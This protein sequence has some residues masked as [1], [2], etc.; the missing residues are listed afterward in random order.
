MKTKRYVRQAV[1]DEMLNLPAFY[2]DG[3]IAKTFNAVNLEMTEWHIVADNDP[4]VDTVEI[5]A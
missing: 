1:A 4:R 2:W 5:E 3:P